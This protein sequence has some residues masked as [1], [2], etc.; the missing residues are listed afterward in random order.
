MGDLRDE[1]QAKLRITLLL[2]ISRETLLKKI[3]LRQYYA[4]RTAF[5]CIKEHEKPVSTA[6]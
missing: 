2:L 1:R 4:E 6:V 5:Y 3:Q